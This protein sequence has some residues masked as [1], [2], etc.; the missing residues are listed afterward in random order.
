MRGAASRL[1]RRKLL[2][3][4]PSLVLLRLPGEPGN[5]FDVRY[6]GAV[7]DATTL[8]TMAINQAIAAAASAGGGTVLFP[9]GTYAS[10]S[11]R[12]R[13]RITLR[14]ARGA[15]LLAAVPRPGQGHGFDRTERDGSWAAY[16]DFGHDH[17]HD[18]LVWGED[19]RDVAIRGPGVIR[20]KGLSHGLGREAGLPTPGTPGAGDKTIALKNCRNV[21]LSDFAILDGGHIGLLATG[22]D[23]LMIENLAIDTD[24]DGMDI[25]CCRNVTITG[26]RVNSPWDDGIAL[27]SSFALGRVQVT[28]NVT[29]RNCTVTGCYRLGALLDGSLRRFP[30]NRG[31]YHASPVGRIKCGTESVG[32]FRNISIRDCTFEGCRGLAI[33]CVDGGTAEDITISGLIMRDIRNAPFFLR[34]GARMRGPPG[35]PAGRLRRVRISDV[36]CQAPG[37]AMP[38]IIC[39]IPGYPIED[40]V[41]ENIRIEQEGGGTPAMARIAPPED[42]RYYPEPSAFGGLPAQGLFLRH[43]RN[44]TIRHV[45]IESRL[46]DARPFVWLG[47]G[48]AVNVTGL[49]LA[50]RAHAPA[51]LLERVRDFHIS[52][53]E[54]L[55]TATF[56]AVRHRFLP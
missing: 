3:L 35:R 52:R 9:P 21:R 39:G 15:T 14:L 41:L 24:R 8:D 19:L 5:I 16:Q 7:G 11:V 38:A 13:S 56:A 51:F 43:V 33:E 22:V 4:A 20:G 45:A 53:S 49:K 25:D 1:Q 48:D 34:L 50:R 2:Q 10:Y 6:F 18:S 27:K 36:V 37:N 31:P 26:C 23:G 32:G 47:A 42:V 30:G 54:P 12:L 29:I 55:P 17:W 46:P 40:I 28:E 44:V